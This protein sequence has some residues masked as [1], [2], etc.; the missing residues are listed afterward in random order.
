MWCVQ[1]TGSYDVEAS[2]LAHLELKDCISESLGW[3]QR[4][5]LQ[6]HCDVSWRPAGGLDLTSTGHRLCG[7][8]GPEDQQ[9]KRHFRKSPLAGWVMVQMLWSL[10]PQQLLL[11]QRPDF[12]LAAVPCWHKELRLLHV[13]RLD[14]LLVS[15]TSTSMLFLTFTVVFIQ[16]GLL[17]N[18]IKVMLDQI[19]T[20]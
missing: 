4:H 18:N 8:S 12:V 6:P 2:T 19:L 17:I 20:F 5:I 13:G 14:I 1:V 9:N 11:S 15:H 3:G 10:L 16:P 7:W